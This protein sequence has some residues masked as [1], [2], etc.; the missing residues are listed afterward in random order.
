MNL[1]VKNDKN[2]M[3]DEREIGDVT[4]CYFHSRG[5]IMFVCLFFGFLESKLYSC[6]LYGVGL[7]L[8]LEFSI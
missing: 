2:K 1:F 6:C 7:L 3:K 5:R 4:S 8:V